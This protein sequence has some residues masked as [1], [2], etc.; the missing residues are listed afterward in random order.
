MVD[1]TVL[2]RAAKKLDQDALASIFDQY[3][4]LLYRYILRLCQNPD[5]ADNLVGDVFARFL[6]Q[7]AAGKGPRTNLRSYLYQVAYHLVVDRSRYARHTAPL[8]AA[9]AMPDSDRGSG[10]ASKIEEQFTLKTIVD[11]MNKYLTIDQ[12]HVLVLRYVEDF[13]L[14]ETSEI[15]GKGIS[16]VKVLEHRGIAKLRQILNQDEHD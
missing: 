2:L 3:A 5:E 14:R 8:E 11:A 10:T 9:I 6:E 15:L 16:S 4:P 7:L 12:R 1:E 13:S